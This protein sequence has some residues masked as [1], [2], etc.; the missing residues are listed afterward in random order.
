[1]PAAHVVD[2][3]DPLEEMSDG[4]FHEIL[5]PVPFPAFSE[6]DQLERVW[7]RRWG[8]ADEV[9]RLRSVLVRRPSAGLEAIARAG[10]A[11]YRPDLGAFLDPDRRWYWAGRE[12]PDLETL[13]REYDGFLTALR[14]EDVEIVEAPALEDRFT[15]AV[16]T[17][18][19]LVTI[20]GGAIIGRL[21]PDM[22]RGEELS[23]TQ[24]VAAHGLP[25]LGTITG[26][27]LVEG[28]SFVKVRRDRAFFGTS[29]R[30]NP[31]GYRQ[32][33]RMLD[34]HG[35]ALERVQMPGFQIHLDLCCLMLDDDLALINPRIAPYDFQVRLHELGI[36]TVAVEP[37]E[38]WACNALVLDRRRVLF[39]SHLPRTAELLSRH[40][41]EVVPVDYREINK[42]GGGLH[43]SSMELRR[44]W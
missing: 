18:D 26:S 8:A 24:T 32:L 21:A 30:C 13:H 35:I 43:C 19:P 17:R 34:Q 29:V 41:V 10:Q 15:K 38:D 12:L 40:G 9:G 22:R 5:G 16:F 11:A 14:A 7:G 39:P 44:D 27:G 4:L 28:G 42:N 6:P 3:P 36:E 20:P 23:I 33:A 37:R 31:E 1:M 2:R 25:I